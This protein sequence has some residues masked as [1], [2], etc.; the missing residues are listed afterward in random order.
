MKKSNII[1]FVFVIF[2]F[3]FVCGEENNNG[4][5]F[6]VSAEGLSAIENTLIPILEH[7]L[8][9]LQ[10]PNP[11]PQEVGTPIGKVTIEASN[12]YIS[13]IDVD[14]YSVNLIAGSGFEMNFK[15]LT[16]QLKFDWKF[17]QHIWPHTH[18]SGDG[19]AGTDDTS[20]TAEIEVFIN[21]QRPLGKTKNFHIDIKNLKIKLH[22][23]GLFSWLLNVFI[24]AFKFIFKDLI[25]NA[26]NNAVPSL[27]DDG[28]ASALGSFPVQASLGTIATIH[29]PFNS[30]TTTSDYIS[31]AIEG[32]T[33]EYQQPDVNNTPFLPVTMPNSL[34]SQYGQIFIS[35]W[36]FNTMLYTLGQQN[37]LS[38]AIAQQTL[39][40]EN[41]QLLNTTSWKSILPAL[42]RNY[43]DQPMRLQFT[44]EKQH[45]PF[46][47]FTQTAGASATIP[48]FMSVQVTKNNT[49]AFVLQGVIDFALN[50][51]VDSQK[52]LILPQ[53]GNLDVQFSL[54]SSN[55]GNFSTLPLKATIKSVLEVGVPVVNAI[56]RKGIPIP[57]I[58]G[59]QFVQPQLIFHQG[60]F[61]ISSS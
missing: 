53:I 36:L 18:A 39:P 16:L 37:L 24:G 43:P 34:T 4:I 8:S 46:V 52:M 50:I 7:Y 12:I 25:Q 41:Q 3:G 32:L 15:K 20:I 56:L 38:F 30:V 54:F 29:F 59:L 47:N 21:N 13:K 51:T 5:K 28:L 9:D 40:A 10:L 31:F 49:E 22:H 44:E 23:A 33:T 11:A 55:I 45:L 1:I 60:Y 14:D 26:L 57:N 58:Q 61:D 48:G 42:Y 2:F 35:D 6:T 17:R 19:E 27:I